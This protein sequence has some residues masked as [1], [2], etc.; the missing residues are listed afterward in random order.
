MSA[1]QRPS[2]GP[3]RLHDV[4][5]REIA[6]EV[7]LVPIRGRLA[8]LQ[9]L[10]VLN[11]VGEWIWE[12]LDGTQSADA[13]AG[14]LAAAFEVTAEE[15]RADVDGFVRELAEAGLLEPDGMPETT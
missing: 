13:L 4:I 9:E 10:F 7:F 12:R 6:G 11:S 8:D 15:A 3:R 14:G 1:A 2:G 5:L